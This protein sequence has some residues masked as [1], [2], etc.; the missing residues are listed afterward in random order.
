[1]KLLLGF[2]L[3]L[4]IATGPAVAQEDDEQEDQSRRRGEQR[5]EIP[6]GEP[7]QFITTT[8]GRF[9]DE[10]IRYTAIAG[11]TFLHN[12]RDE[13]IASI[14]SISYVKDGLQDPKERPLTFIFNGGPGSASLWLHMGIFGPKRIVVPSDGA[15]VGA[16]PY[17]I[18]L[19]PLSILDVT[20]L[21]FVDPVGTGYSRAIGKGRGN[22][23]WGV[24]EDARALADF[25]RLYITE[26]KRWNSPRYLIG[27]SYGTTRVAALVKELQARYNGIAINGVVL[28]SAILDFQ[29]TTFRPGNDYSYVAYLPSFAATAWY[30]KKLENRPQNIETLLDEVRAFAIN[31][32]APALLKGS[33][34]TDTERQTIVTKLA[35][36]TGLSE[37]YLE[38]ANL[39]VSAPRF[40][41]ELLRAEG[42]T[43]GRFDSRYT[44]DD[45]DDAGEVSDDDPAAYGIDAA[46]VTS[47]NDY[48]TRELGV[49]IKR[50]YKILPFEVSR[51]WNWSTG[52]RGGWPGYVNVAPWLGQGM[53]QNNDLKVFVANGYYDLAT[54]FFGT[55][56]TLANNGIDPKR[57]T[58]AYY[59]AGHMMYTH[60]PSLE[61]LASGVRL[62]IS[63]GP[64]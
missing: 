47:I 8:T 35:S 20:D 40:Q 14:F 26:N 7:Q 41:K 4:G 46:Y 49:T 22:D 34:L 11:D 45:Y 17:N 61:K 43:V 31:E 51:A 9:N 32:Y 50:E 42:K 36:Y 54:P 33:R 30:H 63:G 6:V 13:P 28:I 24:R 62:L 1:M 57:V 15:P 21:V 52:R 16:P 10:L 2:M 27:E 58:F 3:A 29:G 23:F 39:R 37:T 38:R 44:G 19:N 55:E 56:N 48:L 5:E 53:R 25:I 12:N 18:A 59:E 60:Q 64:P